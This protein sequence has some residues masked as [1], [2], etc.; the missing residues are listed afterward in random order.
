ML[1][2]IPASRRLTLGTDIKSP[3]AVFVPSDGRYKFRIR[4]GND[5]GF[6]KNTKGY[7]GIT[8]LDNK[9][10]RRHKQFGT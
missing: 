9:A 2:L 4:K 7:F 6:H 10:K 8:K 1:P 5:T 3:L